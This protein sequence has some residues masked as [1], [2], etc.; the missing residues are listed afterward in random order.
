MTDQPRITLNDGSQMPQLGFGVFL[1]PPEETRRLVTDAI[2][3]G[4]HAIDTDTF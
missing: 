2:E 4:Y 3:I 1:V